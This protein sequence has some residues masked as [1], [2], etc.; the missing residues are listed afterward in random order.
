MAEVM[1]CF[2]SQQAGDGSGEHLAVLTGL[3]DHLAKRKRQYLPNAERDVEVSSHVIRA[4]TTQHYRL[5]VT[6][7]SADG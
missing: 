5:V 7:Q 3:L 2:R 4:D 6:G 1:R